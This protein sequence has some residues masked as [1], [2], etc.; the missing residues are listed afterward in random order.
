MFLRKVILAVAA[1]ALVAACSSQGGDSQETS[2]S[3]TTTSTT[4]PTAPV[5]TTPAPPASN[6]G[7]KPSGANAAPGAKAPYDNSPAAYEKFA[8]WWNYEVMTSTDAAVAANLVYEAGITACGSRHSRVGTEAISTVLERDLGFTRSGAAGIYKSALEALCPQY[9][10][11]YQTELDKNTTKM[12]EALKARITFK[13]VPPYHQFGFFLK[14]AC[15]ALA[16]SGGPQLWDHMVLMRTQLALMEKG[17]ISPDILR[18]YIKAAV[19]SGCSALT[20][21]LPPLIQMAY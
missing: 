1:T 16:K 4:S 8:A 2:R 10:L 11:G 7:S 20:T 3:S 15:A 19:S 18:I 12:M 17:K 6:I 5:S 9:N 14:E 21:Q 13:P